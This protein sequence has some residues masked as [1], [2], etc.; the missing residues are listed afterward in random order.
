MIYKSG[1]KTLIIRQAEGNPERKEMLVPV[2]FPEYLF[3]PGFSRIKI[4][5]FFPM[6]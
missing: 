3:V 4:V 5:E 1:T 6:F 2:E